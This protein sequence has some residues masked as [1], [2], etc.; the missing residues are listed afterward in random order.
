MYF[1]INDSDSLNYVF[2]YFSD[3]LN[4]ISSRLHHSL[5]LEKYKI[6]YLL[7]HMNTNIVKTKHIIALKL[8]TI[9][10]RR[11]VRLMCKSASVQKY[12][13]LRYST[14]SYTLGR[15]LYTLL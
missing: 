9:S 3:I 6:I 5:R 13:V 8:V 11:R 1:L 4:Y 12:A 14:T 10:A 7:F 2:D 15:S